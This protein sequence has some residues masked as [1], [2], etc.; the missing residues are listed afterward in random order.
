MN[1]IRNPHGSSSLPVFSSLRQVLLR[2]DRRS[3]VALSVLVLVQITIGFSFQELVHANRWM[4]KDHLLIGT[5]IAMTLLLTWDI[6]PERDIPLLCVGLLGGFVIEWWG[7]TTSL[8]RYF[9]QERPPVWILPA[10]PTAALAIDRLARFCT[11]GV[12]TLKRPDLLYWTIL[13]AILVSMTLF[14]LPGIR[15]PSTWVVLALMVGTIVWKPLPARDLCLLV[16]GTSLGYFLESWGTTRRCWLYYTFETPP[17]IA[18]WAH[19]FAAVTF[20]RGVQLVSA[21]SGRKSETT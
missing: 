7:T 4:W 18:V 20:S 15:V 6:R 19:G 16:A 1:E 2:Y 17:E 14:A 13:P 21:L 10:W 11:L 12:K 8:W 5:W 9:T 3:L